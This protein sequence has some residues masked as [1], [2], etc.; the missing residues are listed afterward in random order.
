[1]S[2]VIRESQVNTEVRCHLAQ[3][4]RAVRKVR[5]NN[6]FF[7]CEDEWKLEL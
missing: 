4:R 1:M 6:S 5:D 3:T 7:V 2:L